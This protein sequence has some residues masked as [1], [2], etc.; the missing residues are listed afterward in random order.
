[1][2]LRWKLAQALE[3]RW[4]KRYLG[5]RPIPEYLSWKKAYWNKFL[6]DNGIIPQ[7]GEFWIDAGCGPAGIFLVLQAPGIACDPLLDRYRSLG[8]FCREEDHPA[9]SFIQ[10]SLEEFSTPAPADRIYCL[11]AINHVRDLKG[12]MKNLKEALRPGGM[13]VLST[14]EHKHDL[15]KLIF[16]LIPGDALHPQQ[17]SSAEYLKIFSE[18]GFDCLKRKVYKG[19]WIFDY[20]VYN[21]I[22]R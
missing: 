13:L 20:T 8:P 22:S 14:D 21:L 2:S 4:W 16:R 15:L 7:A 12:C 6:Q 17:L 10:S 1:M 19:G 18:A 3:W 5:K 11:N 9:V